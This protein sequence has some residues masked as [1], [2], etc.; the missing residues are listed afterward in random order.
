LRKI[1]RKK[2]CK[3]RRKFNK[4]TFNCKYIANK[5]RDERYISYFI[6]NVFQDLNE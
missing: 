6:I 2:H 5:P 3:N 1:T 4:L